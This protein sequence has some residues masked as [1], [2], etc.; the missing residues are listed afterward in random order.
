MVELQR[1]EAEDL[2]DILEN[3]DSKIPV[4]EWR[5]EA[6]KKLRVQWGMVSREVELLNRTKTYERQ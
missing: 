6:A 5:F 2:V 3:C 4:N 1:Y